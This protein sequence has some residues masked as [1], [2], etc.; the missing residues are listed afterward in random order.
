MVS[1]NICV[2]IRLSFQIST[3]KDIYHI[4]A[5]HQ[6]LVSVARRKP[7]E[8]INVL[9]KKKKSILTIL[10]WY[11]W[12]NAP[13]RTGGG[14]AL[15]K[16]P[17]FWTLPRWKL[18]NQSKST[19]NLRNYEWKWKRVIFQKLITFILMEA[20]TWLWFARKPRNENPC[21]GLKPPCLG[22][23]PLGYL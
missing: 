5:F 15:L 10:N 20:S 7:K 6:K 19:C 16:L 14:L 23:S 4:H 3:K 8:I 21:V 11:S 18:W 1:V 9:E 12:E 13:L 17:F 2:K 22:M